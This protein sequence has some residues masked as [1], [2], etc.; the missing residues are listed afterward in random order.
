M[1]HHALPLRPFLAVLVAALA[2][3]SGSNK[4][5]TDAG[6]DSGPTAPVP[7]SPQNSPCS[8]SGSA[9]CCGNLSCQSG[10][11][12]ETTP[13]TCAPYGAL[14][15]SSLPCC[16]PTPPPG[17]WPAGSVAPNL[18][19][20]V[21]DA[22]ISYCFIGGQI[23]DPCSAS[24]WGCTNGLV[25]DSG[26]CALPSTGQ[27]CPRA[28]GGSCEA[29]DDC[30]PYANALVFYCGGAEN[31][32]PC[33]NWGLNCLETAA[34][35]SCPL[36]ANSFTCMEP[37]VQVPPYFQ[38]YLEPEE[39]DP[40]YAETVCGQGQSACV[41]Y[42]GDTAAPACGTWFLDTFD[43]GT[44]PDGG[45][46]LVPVCLETC[47]KPDDCGSLALDCVSGQCVPNFCYAEPDL[48][49]DDIAG[50][51]SQAQPNAPITDNIDVLFKPC[52]HGGANT[53]CLPQDDE[54]WETVTAICYR[55]GDA[56]AGGVGASCDPSGSRTDLGGLCQSGTLCYK[57]TCLPWCDTGNQ[58]VAPCAMGQQCVVFGGALPWTTT[59]ANG[60]GVCTDDCDPY[61]P[62]AQNGCPQTSSQPPFVC[63]PSGTDSDQF[64]PPGACVGGSTAPV[65][66]GAACSPYGWLDPCVSGAVCAPNKAQNGFV[67]GQVCDPSPS[68]GVTEPSCPSSQTCTQQGPPICE[69]DN[70]SANNYVCNH[71]GVCL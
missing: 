27:Q 30:T 16:E 44:Y 11:C 63:K 47:T 6:V 2:A 59:D 33:Q 3:C 17:G 26:K 13:P 43:Y 65:A 24:T 71:I 19:C 51:I 18:G 52:A 55:V 42:P 32:D 70:N 38:I 45:P 69:N 34:A 4:K 10:T 29:G 37:S 64:P 62:A 9:S 25:C 7:C 61:V 22:G 48:E 35:S 36:P 31:S 20:L 58:T 49:G 39:L 57:G 21:S 60:T 53:V 12:Q 5:T 23:G 66:I 14:C 56:T 67:C 28:D 1:R 15:S 41:P 68:P 40:T 50:A 8:G 46:I 54:M